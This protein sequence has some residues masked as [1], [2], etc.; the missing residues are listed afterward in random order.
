MQDRFAV[1][2]T[3]HIKIQAKYGSVTINQ[4]SASGTDDDVNT[5]KV[6]PI[7]DKDDTGGFATKEVLYTVDQAIAAPA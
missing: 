7:S 1:T 6:G 3:E 5:F 4:N 2:E